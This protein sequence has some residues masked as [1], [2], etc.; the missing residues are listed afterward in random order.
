MVLLS[1]GSKQGNDGIVSYFSCFVLARLAEFIE[2]IHTQ[3]IL[4]VEKWWQI[5]ESEIQFHPLMGSD[6]EHTNLRL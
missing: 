5:N 3:N 6:T 2:F 4:P 1:K